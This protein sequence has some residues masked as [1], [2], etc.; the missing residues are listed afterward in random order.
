MAASAAQN[1]LAEAL[2]RDLYRSLAAEGGWDALVDRAAARLGTVSVPVADRTE[3][4][5]RLALHMGRAQNPTIQDGGAGTGL[6]I[7]GSSRSSST[8]H[9]PL[10]FPADWYKSGHGQAL[11]GILSSSP[12][13]APQ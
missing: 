9:L 7:P 4:I 13:L 3:A 1:A 12:A 11:I 2:D 5:V 10:G 8:A 6:S